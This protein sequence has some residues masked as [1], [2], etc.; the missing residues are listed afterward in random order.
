MDTMRSICG[1]VSPH[2]HSLMRYSLTAQTRVT[3][4]YKADYFSLDSAENLP[5][6]ST[7]LHSIHHRST[8]LCL[9]SHTALSAPPR[10]GTTTRTASRTSARP[11][12]E[13]ASAGPGSSKT[14]TSE[15]RRMVGR[16]FCFAALETYADD[17]FSDLRLEQAEHRRDGRGDGAPD[18]RPDR[19]VRVGRTARPAPAAASTTAAA[20]AATL[21]AGGPA[22]GLTRATAGPFAGVDVVAIFLA[23]GVVEVVG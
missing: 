5:P 3:Q 10:V 2:N 14:P 17:G 19:H 1:E 7:A 16:T 22:F 23:A 4:V 8:T 6:S 9:T 21:L 20:V 15:S 13:R 18:A 11:T 12:T